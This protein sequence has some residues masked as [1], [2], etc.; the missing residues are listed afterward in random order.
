M[1]ID[2]YFNEFN[3]CTCGQAESFQKTCAGAEC[4]YR[5]SEKEY[6]KRM[7]DGTLPQ[8]KQ[9]RD[10]S[11]EK[12]AEIR[13]KLSPEKTKKQLKYERKQEEKKMNPGTGYSLKDDPR[14][15]DLFG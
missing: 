9:M 10:D 7:M 14:F 15:K 1:K 13:K 5:I 2:C 11:P 8:E 12:K 3:S 6:F 4:E